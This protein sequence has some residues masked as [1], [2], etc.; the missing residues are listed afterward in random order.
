MGFGRGIRGRRKVA[1]AMKESATPRQLS[2]GNFLQGVQVRTQKCR[3]TRNCR[4][5]GSRNAAVHHPPPSRPFLLVD[6]PRIQPRAAVQRDEAAG[7]PGSSQQ[8]SAATRG[9]LTAPSR[10]GLL[11]ES[12]TEGHGSSPLTCAWC[13]C[14]CGRPGGNGPRR[15]T[16]SAEK[17]A[18]AA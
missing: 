15:G 11:R 9:R 5:A 6:P 18:L 17:S 3:A 4:A 16:S 7:K 8:A 1:A 12:P 14:G 13:A 10:P 2:V